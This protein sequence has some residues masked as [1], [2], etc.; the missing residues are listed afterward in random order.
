MWELK[1]IKQRLHCVLKENKLFSNLS[2]LFTKT[3]AKQ[4]FAT[5]IFA[6]A[7]LGDAALGDQAKRVLQLHGC[8]SVSNMRGRSSMET[9]SQS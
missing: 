3:F 4:I 8:Q 9:D 1:Y 6:K 2:S 7:T 5:Q